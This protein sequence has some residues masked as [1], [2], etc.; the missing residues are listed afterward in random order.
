MA[1]SYNSY[2]RLLSG[3]STDFIRVHGTLQWNGGT[4]GATFHQVIRKN[5]FEA[6]IYY[7]VKVWQALS[8]WGSVSVG[9]IWRFRI[10]HS[11]PGEAPRQQTG[12]LANSVQ[13]NRV[14]LSAGRYVIS[15]GTQVPYAHTLEYGG[16]AAELRDK[17][18]T[19]NRLINPIKKPMIIAPRPVWR[20]VFYQSLSR[21]IDLIARGIK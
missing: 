15:I 13:S 17:K 14:S 20:P 18:Y 21:M 16:I 11:K 7:R 2:F 4:V 8:K 9:G 10:H 3:G 12:N 6:A 1:L 19:T 5:M